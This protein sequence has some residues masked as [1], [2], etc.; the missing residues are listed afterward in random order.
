MIFLREKKIILVKSSMKFVPMSPIDNKS[1]L[2]QV[3][4]GAQ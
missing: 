2:V 4:L 3:W 1:K